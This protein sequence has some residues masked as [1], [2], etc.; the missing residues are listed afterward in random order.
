[1][2]LKPKAVEEKAANIDQGRRKL[3]KNDICPIC[4]LQADAVDVLAVRRQ[5]SQHKGV[6]LFLVQ[7]D[8]RNTAES[9]QGCLV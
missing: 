6:Q 9:F 1:M 5:I 7:A 3:T 4:T 8:G 2:Q